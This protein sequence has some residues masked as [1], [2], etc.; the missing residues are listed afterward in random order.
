VFSVGVGGA[1]IGRREDCEISLNA[2]LDLM[3]SSQHGRIMYADGQWTYEDLNSTNG[4]IVNGRI[5]EPGVPIPLRDGVLIELGENRGEGTVAFAVSMAAK[6]ASQPGIDIS[7][8]GCGQQFDVPRMMMGRRVDCPSCGRSV[9][10]PITIKLLNNPVSYGSNG[11][12]ADSAQPGSAPESEEPLLGQTLPTPPSPGDGAPLPPPIFPGATPVGRSDE[13]GANP[14]GGLLGKVRNAVKNFREKHEVQNEIKL[15]E[16][17]HAS[18]VDAIRRE[19]VEVGKEAWVADPKTSIT[20]DGGEE[21]AAG[22]SSIEA[23]RSELRQAEESLNAASGVLSE[24]RERYDAQLAEAERV[25]TEAADRDR[26]ARESL[27]AAEREYRGAIDACLGDSSRVI[28]QIQAI[29]DADLGSFDPQEAL[30]RL[31]SLMSS[32]AT[33]INERIGT[34]T[35]PQE[36]Y[37]RAESTVRVSAEALLEASQAYSALE[38]DSKAQ[39]LELEK[40]VR[41]AE[42]EVNHL[43]Q[44]I[45]R[46]E[47]ELSP[48]YERLGKAVVSA[49]GAGVLGADSRVFSACLAKHE[50]IVALERKI[51]ELKARLET[52]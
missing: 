28:D 5:V 1:T 11:G 13:P 10:V 18:L 7:C 25:R 14:I 29:R 30:Q 32:V 38:A 49:V 51:E 50:R 31:A 39:R 23:T 42:Q 43:K 2:E 45:G 41:K 15:C 33:G 40:S 16:Q 17:E 12:S 6:P 36:Q 3:V 21:L 46:L 47:L 19:F 9:E 44:Q 8:P 24:C 26:E 4:S 34:L 35:T 20:L 27:H 48:H 22:F 52:L 37:R